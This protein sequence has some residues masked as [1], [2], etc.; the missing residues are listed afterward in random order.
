MDVGTCGSPRR[1]LLLLCSPSF[2]RL[3]LCLTDV[4][5]GYVA[6]ACLW[7]LLV[8]SDGTTPPPH[9]QYQRTQHSNV[10]FDTFMHLTRWHAG[11]ADPLMPLLWT[12]D[13]SQTVTFHPAAFSGLT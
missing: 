12:P 7:L 4:P 6:L 2:S 5:T 13:L 3:R 10:Y 8:C 1:L 11:A 9:R